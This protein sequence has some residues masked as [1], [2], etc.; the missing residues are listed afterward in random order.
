MNDAPDTRH[1]PKGIKITD[2][3]AHALRI[4]HHKFHGEWNYTL[5]PEHRRIPTEV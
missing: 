3:Q 5:R 4:T 1:Y 2:E